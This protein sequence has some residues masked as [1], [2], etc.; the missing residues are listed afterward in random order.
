M[1]WIKILKEVVVPRYI[2]FTDKVERNY[3]I[4]AAG[5][6]CMTHCHALQFFLDTNHNSLHENNENHLTSL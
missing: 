4:P 6:K 2:A 5:T 3:H 1:S